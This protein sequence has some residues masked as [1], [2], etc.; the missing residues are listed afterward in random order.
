[1]QHQLKASLAHSPYKLVQP[2]RMVTVTVGEGQRLHTG[3]IHIQGLSVE[4]RSLRRESEVE[5]DGARHSICG[6]GDQ[7]RETML[8]KNTGDGL[9]SPQ[10]RIPGLEKLGPL[11]DLAAVSGEKVHV[12]VLKRQDLEL[13]YLIDDCGHCVSSFL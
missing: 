5:E 7:C 2:S 1:M 8:R 3:Q 13:I 9:P 4:G 11:Q 6:R 10:R 12:V